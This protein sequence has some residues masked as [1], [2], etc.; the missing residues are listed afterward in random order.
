[1]NSLFVS[2]LRSLWEAREPSITTQDF[3]EGIPLAAITVCPSVMKMSPLLAKGQRRLEDLKKGIVIKREESTEIAPLVTTG[4]KLTLL[5]R[6]RA[7]SLHNSTLPPPPTKAELARKAALGRL[8]EVVAVLGIL[9]TASSLGQQRVS[10]TLPT[11]VGKLKD[12][13]KNPISKEEAETCVR[14][15]AEI[16]PEWF[17]LAKLGRGKMEALV[18]D[19]EG[20]VA[21]E[22]IRER[23]RRAGMLG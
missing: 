16:V 23:V 14:L 5:E 7:K 19:R 13:L 4:K 1:M 21:D 17:K 11:I 22:E 20:K 18:V 2:S 15:L 12:S 6:L 3:I 9:S 10:F 8:D